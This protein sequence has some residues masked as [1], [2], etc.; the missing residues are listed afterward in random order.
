M[1]KRIVYDFEI[2]QHYPYFNT[3]KYNNR[4]EIAGYLSAPT[5]SFYWLIAQTIND[6]NI[7]KVN[8]KRGGSTLKFRLAQ[9]VNPVEFGRQIFRETKI[10]NPNII[11]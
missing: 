4:P 6:K 10:K 9:K 1:Y 7:L 2:Y 3:M 11:I 8:I 5:D